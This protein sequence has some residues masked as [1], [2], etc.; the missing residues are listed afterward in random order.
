MSSTTK[1]NP[2]IREAAKLLREITALIGK[3]KA[4]DVSTDVAAKAAKIH[5]K[6]RHALSELHSLND[7]KGDA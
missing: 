4:A 6:A 2:H 3:I 1:Q 5:G 7:S